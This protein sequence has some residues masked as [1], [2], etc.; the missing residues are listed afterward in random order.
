MQRH[1]SER[2]GS[3]LAMP[4]RHK[5]SNPRADTASPAIE[6]PQRGPTNLALNLFI[7]LLYGFIDPRVTYG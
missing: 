4:I 2:G 6:S 5:H 1:P 7:D 3:D